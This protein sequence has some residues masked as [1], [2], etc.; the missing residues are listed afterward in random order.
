MSR[1]VVVCAAP[2][3]LGTDEGA[4]GTGCAACVVAG[5]LTGVVPALCGEECQRPKHEDTAEQD[6]AEL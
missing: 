2:D 3:A 5:R 4:R 1:L 6:A